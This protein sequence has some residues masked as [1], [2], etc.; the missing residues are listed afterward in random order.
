LGQIAESGPTRDGEAADRLSASTSRRGTPS[1]SRRPRGPRPP[2][3]SKLARRRSDSRRGVPGCR[4]KRQRPPGG[5][6]DQQRR[7]FGRQHR[8]RRD[9]S[10]AVVA[11]R[12]DEPLANKNGQHERPGDQ[13]SST[14]ARRAATSVS[15][16]P[17]WQRWIGRSSTRAD[18]LELGE[19]RAGQRAAGP[20]GVWKSGDGQRRKGALAQHGGDLRPCHACI[21][22]G[23]WVTD[24]KRGGAWSHG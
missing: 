18:S 5:D 22:R 16:P 20:G 21:P 14:S 11:Q 8:P 6:E 24:D 4:S 15:R 3:R 12:A 7:D 9:R 10:F 13:A 19:A 23:R 17:G 1:G 2:R